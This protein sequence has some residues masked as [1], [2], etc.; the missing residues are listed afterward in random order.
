VPGAPADVKWPGRALLRSP[1]TSWPGLQVGR[2]LRRMQIEVE[3]LL[4]QARRQ[5]LKR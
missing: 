2:A 1:V 5:A 4:D 3:E